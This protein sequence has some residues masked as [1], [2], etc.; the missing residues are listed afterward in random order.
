MRSCH[1]NIPSEELDNPQLRRFRKSTV[2]GGGIAPLSNTS[3]Q[4]DVP[5]VCQ[6]QECAE[7]L[8]QFRIGSDFVKSAVFS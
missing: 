6:Q 5:K 8:F 4:L 3:R 2:N 1:A 7:C